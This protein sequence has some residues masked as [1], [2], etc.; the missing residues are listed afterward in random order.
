A[1]PVV[2]TDRENDFL[3]ANRRAEELFA[4]RPDDSEGRRRAIRVNDLMF[5]SFLTQS[6]MGGPAAANRE[7]NLVDPN[8]G[9]DLLF[10]VMSVPLPPGLHREGAVISVLRDI[11]DLKRALTELEVQFSRS[12]AAERA[13]RQE[14]DRLAVV[15]SNVGD[16]ILVTDQQSNISLMNSRAERLFEADPAGPALA[17]TS[18]IVQANDT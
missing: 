5:S 10:E 16:P 18:R 12:R 13:A 7:L 3:F 6:I 4:N 11:T 14:S 8:D 1:D 15:L 17:H 2:L 9:S